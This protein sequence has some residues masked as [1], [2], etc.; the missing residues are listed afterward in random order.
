M[1][2]VQDGMDSEFRRV[3]AEGTLELV[4]RLPPE[5]PVTDREITEF[6]EANLRGRSGELE[7]MMRRALDAVPYPTFVPSLRAMAV[8]E[9][10]GIVWV[11]GF[12]AAEE[13]APWYLFD[14]L[15][16]PVGQVTVPDGNPPL[17]IEGRRIVVRDRDELDVERILIHRLAELPSDRAGRAA[18]AC[19]R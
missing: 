17:D 16:C 19:P 3:R 6:R 15:G 13:P 2:W 9:E 4:V 8:D 18:S 5:R 10:A 14:S 7:A 1:L 12:S 11:T